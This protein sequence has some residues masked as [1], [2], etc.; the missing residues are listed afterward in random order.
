MYAA[1]ILNSYGSPGSSRAAPPLV[2]CICLTTHP[3][4]AAFL[5]DALRSYRQQT[6][7][8]RELV[9]VNDGEPLVSHADDVRVINLPR[10]GTRWCIGEKRNAGI[11]FARGEYIA[12]WDDDDLSFP[13]RLTDQVAAARAWNAD[14]VRADA[15]FIADA[16]LSLAGRC[17]RD[18]SKPVMPSAMIRR[19]AAVA[20]GG[21]P[22]VDYL[23]DAGLIERIRLLSRGN[24]CTMRDCRWYVM[25]RHGSNVTLSSGES[26]DTYAACGLRDRSARDAAMAIEAMRQGPGGEDVR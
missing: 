8:P 23:E 24:V 22:A 19:D 21:Y 2:T 9:V 4:R 25:R 13:Q 26:N 15:M 1:S 10:R 6:Y 14:V 11:R 18:R 5:P 12:T 20:A 3:K 7:S 16:E 17:E